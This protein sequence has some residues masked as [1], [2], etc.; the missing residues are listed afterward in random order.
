[1]HGA[2]ARATTQPV[3]DEGLLKL[4][5]LLRIG[6]IGAA[7]GLVIGF[8]APPITIGHRNDSQRAFQFNGE[9]QEGEIGGVE[10]DAS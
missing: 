10:H 1:M 5:Y 3:I 9:I 2:Q 8:G 4:K 7:Y 6:S